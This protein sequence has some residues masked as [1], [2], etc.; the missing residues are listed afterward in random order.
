MTTRAT[1]LTTQTPQDHTTAAITEVITE[2]ITADTPA[3][4]TDRT[5]AGTLRRATSTAPVQ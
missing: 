4:T 2:A 3:A 1:H 5:T